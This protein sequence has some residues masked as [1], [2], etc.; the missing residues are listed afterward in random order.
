MKIE[1]VDIELITEYENNAKKHPEWQIEQI[2]KSIQEFGFNDPIAID[3]DN[4][5]IEGH[6]RYLACKKLGIKEVPCVRLENMSEEQKRAYIIAHNKLTLNTEFDLEKL[7]YELNALKLEGIDLEM[8]G[9][10]DDEVRDFFDKTE[11]VFDKIKENP[12][13]SNLNQTFLVPPFSILD[14]KTQYWQERKKAWL[15][16]GI[17]SELGRDDSLLFCDN[18]KTGSLGG[19][20]VF[21]PVM[22]EI[23]YLWFTPS[24]EESNILDVFAGGSVRGVVAEQ[25]NNKYI[26]IELRKEQ[27]EANI[28]NAKEIGCD[29]SKIDWINDDSQNIDKYVDDESVDLIFTC[30]PYHDLEVYSDNERDI[31]NMSFSE[32]SVVYSNILTKAIKK[33]KN[34]R[35]AIVV[36]SD[37]RDK[38]GFYRDLTGI[39]YRDL[40]G[41]TKSVFIKNGVNFYNDIILANAIGTGAIRARRH[42]NN[43]KVVRLH[44]NVLVFYKGDPKKIKDEFGV[45]GNVD[46]SFETGES[47]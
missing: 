44:Q 35:F 23:A 25:T 21:D 24:D 43:R 9:F 37:I 26:G 41:I 12:I 20:S 39:F 14:T 28:K 45:V 47:D 34:N 30:P 7:E 2:A 8:L 10:D 18:L 27:V 22:C 36:I 38:N 46:Y 29:L 3:E 13:D 17:K 4:M 1:L 32:F 5:I 11:N 19:T 42:M 40:T 31:S 15:S 33:L 16:K 6:G